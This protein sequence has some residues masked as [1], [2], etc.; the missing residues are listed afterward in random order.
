MDFLEIR[1]RSIGTAL[2]H[3]LIAYASLQKG[4]GKLEVNEQRLAED[5]D[6]AWEVLAE[7]IQTV[8][9]QYGIENPYEQLKA[10]TRGK[11]IDAESLREFVAG[12]DIPTDARDRL[13]EL[14]P[15]T[16]IGVAPGLT[17]RLLTG[18]D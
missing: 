2:G 4:L 7:P 1:V 15:A 18:E 8:M 5:L 12:L 13:L 3:G 9:R 6:G 16:Y 11:A 10:L 17:R 14:T